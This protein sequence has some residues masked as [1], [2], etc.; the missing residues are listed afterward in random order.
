MLLYK[1]S[2]EAREKWHSRIAV[3]S[4]PGLFEGHFC[5]VETFDGTREG[6]QFRLKPRNDGAVARVRIRVVD[7]TGRPVI[8]LP[9][10]MLEP[11]KKWKVTQKLN[12]GV[13][14]AYV[15]LEGCLAHQSSFEVDDIPF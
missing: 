4:K 14:H 15:Y 2:T 7:H 13:Y 3:F 6:L 12:D 11:S 1:M 9:E 5:Y 8:D 10:K